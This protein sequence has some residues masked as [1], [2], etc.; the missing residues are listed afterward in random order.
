MIH[1]CYLE[2]DPQEKNDLAAY[3]TFRDVRDNLA[4]KI[5]ADW[6]PEAVIADMAVRRES[7][8]LMKAWG[9]SV[10]PPDT[11]RWTLLE[12]YN[13]LDEEFSS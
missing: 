1:N 3:P 7:K 2:A 8:E 5:L 6:D 13:W 12:E 11:H 10:L 4:A 9:H